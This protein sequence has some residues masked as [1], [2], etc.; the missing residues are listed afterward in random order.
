MFLRY[1]RCIWK[2]PCDP[3]KQQKAPQETAKMGH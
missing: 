2:M 1:S 3:H